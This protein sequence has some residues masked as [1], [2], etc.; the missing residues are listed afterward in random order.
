M[1]N[2]GIG[3]LVLGGLFGVGASVLVLV[4]VDDSP[5]HPKRRALLLPFASPEGGGAVLQGSF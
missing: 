3:A 5:A 2:L 4:P 1:G